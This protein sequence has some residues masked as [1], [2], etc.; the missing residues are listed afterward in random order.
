[1]NICI[2]G[3]HD[4]LRNQEIKSLCSQ[5]AYTYSAN[6]NA[7]YPFS[8]LFTSI[9]GRT[10]TRLEGMSDAAYKRW[11][12]T[13]WWHDGY[14]RLWQAQGVPQS[15]VEINPSVRTDQGNS[16]ETVNSDDKP[17]GCEPQI[18]VRQHHDVIYLT[19]DSEEELIDLKPEEI[20]I[21]GGICDHNRYK[22][23][24]T[25]SFYIVYLIFLILESVSQ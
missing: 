19:A 23:A 16:E 25:S 1:M 14:E 18:A 20:Y 8:L 4:N 9:N 7:C 22:V 3:N 15:I 10:F 2:F 12:N 21:I 24:T 6:R 13:E 5:L 17:S 11:V